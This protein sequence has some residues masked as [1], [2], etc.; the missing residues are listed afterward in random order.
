MEFLEP[1]EHIMD[2]ILF[3]INNL[4][5]N[6]LETKLT[7]MSSQ[8]KPEHYNWFAKYLFDH[9]VSIEPNNHS[10]YLQ[11]LD[12]LALP[13]MYKKLIMKL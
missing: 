11:F 12:K 3:I 5:F 13:H 6:N 4:A 7:E 2:K 8:I 9:R 10:L 1:E